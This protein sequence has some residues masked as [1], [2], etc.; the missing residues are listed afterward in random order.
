MSSVGWF[1]WEELP[2]IELTSHSV[3]IPSHFLLI[4]VTM[5]TVMLSEWNT[6]TG[7]YFLLQQERI[8]VSKLGGNDSGVLAKITRPISRIQTPK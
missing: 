7:E 4:T 5:T 3:L 1:P 6:K 8:G 2:V